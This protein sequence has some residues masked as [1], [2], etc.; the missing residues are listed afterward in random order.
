LL[1]NAYAISASP[2]LSM[3]R[4]VATSGTP[5]MMSVD[6][7]RLAPVLF[8]GFQDELD[9]GLERDE[10]VGS[11]PDR[12]L[13]EPVVAHPLHVFL[14]DDPPDAGGQPSVE[15]HEIGPSPLQ[16][17]ANASRVD[18]VDRRDVVLQ[19]L[20][21]RAAV[22]LEGELDVLGGERITVVETDTLSQDELVREPIRRSA[23]R[24]GQARRERVTGQRLN[25]RVVQGVEV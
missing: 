19:H 17:E 3:T 14:G 4:R 10:L 8:V 18:D 7:G 22:T 25:Q 11:C 6:A 21:G 23:P 13:P 24:F 2:R 16:T 5:R 12:R 1:A 15:G 20:G 9:T